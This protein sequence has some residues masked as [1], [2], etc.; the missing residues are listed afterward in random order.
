[1]PEIPET[2]RPHAKCPEC[3]KIMPATCQMFRQTISWNR[4]GNREIELTGTSIYVCSAK[5]CGKSWIAND[6]RVTL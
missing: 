6:E 1:M 2:P 3:D 4:D 5:D